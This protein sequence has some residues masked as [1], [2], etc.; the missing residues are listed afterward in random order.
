M[1]VPGSNVA[2]HLR[3]AALDEPDALAT[4]TPLSVGPD[5]KVVHARCTFR[6]LDQESD[7][8]ARIFHAEGIAAGTRTL[9]AVRP[10]H[11][12]I[13]T[14]FGLLKLGAIPVAIDPGM[15]WSPF[16]R[17][18]RHTEPEALVGVRAAVWLSRTPL[19]AFR[20]LRARLTIGTTRWR[21]LREQCAS[22]EPRP[23]ADVSAAS[24]AAILFTSGSTGAPKGVDYT[25]GM[26]DAQI[27]LVRR[28]YRL[29]PGEVD[30]PMLP[31]FALFNPALR[32]ATVTP[33][34][35]PSRPASADPA[36]IVAAML[37]E[38]VTTSFGSPAVWGR[39]ADHCERRGLHLPSLRRVL[40]AGAPVPDGLLA[41]LRR[42]APQAQVHTP[43]GAT[44]CLPVS[45]ITSA[46]LFGAHGEAARRGHGTCVGRAV[47]GVEIRVIREVDGPLRT[48][49]ET[50]ACAPGEIGEIIATGPSVTRAYHRL[51]EATAAAKIADGERIW[52]RMGDLGA[53]GTDGQLRFLGRRAEKVRTARGDLP[54]EAVEPAFR[55]H[56]DVARCALVALGGKAPFRPALVVEPREGRFPADAGD[57]ERF[58][59]G[60]R[61]C[62]QGNAA[63]TQVETFLFQAKLP[64][65]VRHNAK[66]HRL[67]LAREWTARLQADRL[68]PLRRLFR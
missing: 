36:P 43:Y 63:A 14:M 34:L 18:V 49:A 31:L 24:P 58:I 40:I 25:H 33:L 42:L 26:L 9:L 38:K 65:D 45:T 66:I 16:L 53:L 51:P 27:E 4:L 20:S 21:R 30:M 35:D 48:L 1:I 46:E 54:T 47:E 55:V 67:R 29:Q 28:T 10:G 57:R 19:P 12:L 23:L 44:E 5:G 62:A 41:Q 32:V 52:H 56:P 64:V 68:N 2:R 13:V 3:Q 11:D 7:A 37:A 59:A 60:L 6:R 39:L 50:T 61:A 8:A 22:A 15:G 17:C